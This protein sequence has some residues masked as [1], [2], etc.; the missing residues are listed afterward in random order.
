MHA[1]QTT[2]PAARLDRPVARHRGHN[3]QYLGT[4]KDDSGTPVG[5]AKVTISNKST[6]IKTITRSDH[7]GAYGF[8]TLFPGTYDLQA[9]ADGFAS[10]DRSG[11]VMHVNT[12]KRVD[13]NLAAEKH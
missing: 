4:L 5:G 3:W 11:L 12:V 6:G 13:L 10:E 2:I 9:E 1:S 7:K 8:L